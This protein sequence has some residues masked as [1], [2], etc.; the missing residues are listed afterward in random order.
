VNG[1]HNLVEVADV[2]ED[3]ISA[4]L[5]AVTLQKKVFSYSLPGESQTSQFATH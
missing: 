3:H 2:S 4:I 5:H 1:E